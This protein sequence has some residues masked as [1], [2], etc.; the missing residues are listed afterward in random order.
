MNP[1]LFIMNGNVVICSSI[2]S[3]RA[4]STMFMLDGEGNSS[5]FRGRSA[6]PPDMNETVKAPPAPLFLNKFKKR[7]IFRLLI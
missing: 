7:S 3:A 2:E 1:A 4:L 6:E 5:A